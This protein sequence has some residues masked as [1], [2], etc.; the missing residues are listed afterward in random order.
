MTSNDRS[1]RFFDEED[2]TSEHDKLFIYLLQ[3]WKQILIDKKVEQLNWEAFEIIGEPCLEGYPPLF[4]DAII[5]NRNGE[6]P[7]ILFEIKPEIDSFSKVLRQLRLYQS[8]L[9]LDN[10]KIILVTHETKF[11]EIFKSQFMI[12]YHPPKE[13]EP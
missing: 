6:C 3:N 7:R 9:K 12:C 5:K 10:N 11:D 4:P 1:L 8:R 13:G 2:F